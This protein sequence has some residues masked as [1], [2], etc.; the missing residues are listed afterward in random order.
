MWSYKVFQGIANCNRRMCWLACT[1]AAHL[2]TLGACQQFFSR[3]DATFGDPHI[4]WAAEVYVIKTLF[5]VSQ[6]AGL[7]LSAV[8]SA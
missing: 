6:I 8:G 7:R 3:C 1:A 2:A 4:S 5:P